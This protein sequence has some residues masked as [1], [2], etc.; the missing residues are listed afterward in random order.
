MASVP[1]FFGLEENV[2]ESLMRSVHGAIVA[3]PESDDP[4][5]VEAAA[6]LRDQCGVRVFGKEELLQL[7][8]KQAVI[9]TMHETAA[10]RGKVVKAELEGRATDP[11][12]AA[13]HAVAT[14]LCSAAVAGCATPTA[15]VV[16]AILS[17]V[18]LAEGT[19]TLTSVFLMA[20]SRPTPGG[21][22]L[23]VFGDAGVVPQPNPEQLADIGE[24]SARA[25]VQWTGR[26]PVLGFLSFS[27]AGSAEHNDVAKVRAAVSQFGARDSGYRA[28]GEIQF[29]AAIV[30]E[31]AHRKLGQAG[32]NDAGRC[33]VLIFPDLDAGN[34]CY[35]AVERLAGAQAWGPVVLGASRPFS[36]LSRGCSARDIVHV[37]CLALAQARALPSA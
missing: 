1:C 4:R 8:P 6:I 11:L 23:L 26:R 18:G 35:K 12:F 22:S 29:D 9:Q 30:P 15:D 32:G 16:R 2:R 34:I 21:E 14:G 31:V 36:D 24:L 10:R 28:F 13:G 27:T 17:T 3:L 19:R 20:L 37:S 25:F 7:A 33:N 5:V